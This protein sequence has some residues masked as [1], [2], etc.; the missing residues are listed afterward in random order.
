MRKTIV[1]YFETTT[2]KSADK[3]SLAHDKNQAT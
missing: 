2:Q 3:K 1:D